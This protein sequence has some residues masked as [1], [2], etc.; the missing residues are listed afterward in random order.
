MHSNLEDLPL[1]QSPFL[2]FK[3]NQV[4]DYEDRM[5]TDTACSTL[6]ALP[7]DPPR[8]TGMDPLLFFLSGS[9]CR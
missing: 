2:S 1:L 8:Q 5:G 6:W 3:G 4:G 9:D 7:S